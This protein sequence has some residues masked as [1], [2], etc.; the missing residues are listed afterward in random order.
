MDKNKFSRFANHADVNK[1]ILVANVYG[2]TKHYICSPEQL[3]IE[4]FNEQEIN[5][6]KNSLR[7]EEY[8]FIAYYD[9]HEFIR[10]VENGKIDLQE[11]NL[12]FNLARNGFGVSKKSLIPSFCDYYGI[13]Y[14]GS[15]GYTCSLARNKHHV[16][17]LLLHNNLHGLKT[18]VYDDRWQ[19]GLVPE[20][21]IEVIIKPL[22]ESASK[23]I[24]SDCIINT[25]DKNFINRVRDKYSELQS[26]LVIEQF[27]RG[28]ECKV[29]VFAL[30]DITVCDP[31]GI[32]INGNCNLDNMILTQELSYH[33]S[34][35][36]YILSD[37]FDT[38]VIQ[39]IKKNVIKVFEVLGMENY[40]RIDCRIT[41]DGNFYF[42]DY[43]T[44]PYFT[45]HSEI[46]FLFSNINLSHGK[47]FNVIFNSALNT[48]YH[49]NV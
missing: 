26:P 23:G 24:K 41:P 28:F 44:M 10:D 6:I 42:Y 49:Y 19:L 15:N 48:K 22:F 5:D 37:Y 21:D 12:V 7:E 17:N 14:T 13:M 27:I 43:A 45:Q 4:F 29:P 36:N 47:L 25:S 46:S 8:D 31:V 33:Y 30:N 3:R 1:I 40:G 38:S 20:T 18:W 35:A 16:S 2:G 34:Y 9:E 11:K 32:C 39:E